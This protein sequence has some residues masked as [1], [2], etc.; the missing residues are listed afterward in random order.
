MEWYNILAL[1]FT[2]IGGTAGLIALYKAKAE[3]TSIDVG[4]MQSMLDEAHKMYD[5]M[6]NEKNLVNEEFRSYKEDNMKYIA[7]FKERFAKVEQRLDRTEEE[8]FRLRGAIYQGY[9]CRYPDNIEDCPVVKEY[10]KSHC[11]E[12]EKFIEK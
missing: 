11:G 6:K 10:E 7:E 5:E 2:A 12:C 3:K 4:N 9:R 8:V 1:V